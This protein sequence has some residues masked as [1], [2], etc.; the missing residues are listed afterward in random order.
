MMTKKDICRM[1]EITM[2]D[3]EDGGSD[4]RLTGMID[5]LPDGVKCCS[6]TLVGCYSLT[7]LPDDLKVDYL[8]IIRCPNLLVFPSKLH[9]SSLLIEDSDISELP[10][11][12]S[13]SSS[14]IL[15]NCPKLRKLPDSCI[16]FAENLV[17]NECISISYLPN[18]KIIFGNLCIAGTSI[19]HLPEN[20]KIGGS[21]VV[22]DSDLETLPIGIRIGENIDLS[23]C[24]KLKSLPEGLIVNG[25]LNLSESSITQLP[26]RLIV[27]ENLNIISTSIKSLPPDLL[28]RNSVLASEGIVYTME[29]KRDF[30]P[31]LPSLIWKDSGYIQYEN[32]LFR[33][34]YQDDISWKVLDSYT[35]VSIIL[36]RNNILVEDEI[37]IVTN[38]ANSYGMGN[39]LQEAFRDLFRRN[40]EFDFDMYN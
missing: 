21:L 16:A 14:M 5:D 13:C 17:L 35:V 2:D 10:E 37:Y 40:T 22:Y 6:L 26:G 28:V 15:K 9:L 25:S 32:T 19:S 18:I 8:E 39:R 27:G 29:K 30:P 23:G 3:L 38:G 24:K 36:E 11:D 34:I 4:I 31:C 20:I 33:I 1:A 12:L 7:R